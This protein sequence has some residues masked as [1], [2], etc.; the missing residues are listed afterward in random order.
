MHPSHFSS[1]IKTSPG[2]IPGKPNYSEQYWKEFTELIDFRNGLV[3]GRASRPDTEG[4]S[5]AEKPEPT[6]EQLAQI[7]PGWAVKVAADVIKK[8]HEAVGTPPP[9][10]IDT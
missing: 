5:D 6:S 4:L 2:S 10:W 1:K 3:H 8:L 9:A 7:G